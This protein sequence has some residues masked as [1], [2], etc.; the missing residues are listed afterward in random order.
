MLLGPS[1]DAKRRGSRDSEKS[2]KIPTFYL[3]RIDM[4]IRR[5]HIPRDDR[6][7]PIAR[8]R[9]TAPMGKLIASPRWQPEFDI[10]I[11]QANEIA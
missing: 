6:P 2:L 9:P 7:R 8:V 5:E 3:Q 10:P 11:G 1:R 4:K